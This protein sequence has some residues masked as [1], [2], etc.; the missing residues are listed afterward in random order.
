M[1]VEMQYKNTVA[2]MKKLLTTADAERK[3]HTRQ[4]QFDSLLGQIGV[5][6]VT[7]NFFYSLFD[8]EVL[9]TKDKYRIKR[10]INRSKILH[11][12][13]DPTSEQKELFVLDNG[14]MPF[15]VA[16]YKG[17]QKLADMR[18][19]PFLDNKPKTTFFKPTSFFIMEQEVKTCTCGNFENRCVCVSV[20]SWLI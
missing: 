4:K 15:T 5:S 13:I 8:T 14:H 16:H 11:K 7:R 2:E 6:A 3:T 12:I 17:I 19:L 20:P 18:F 10:F 1:T 9:Y